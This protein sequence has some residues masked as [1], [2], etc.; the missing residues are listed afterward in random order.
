MKTLADYQELVADRPSKFAPAD[1]WYQKAPEGSAIICAA[2]IHFYHRAIDGFSVCE[3]LR[4]PETDRTGVRP[5]WRC[6]FQT[7]DGDVF[8]L[9]EN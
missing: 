2:C 3:I 9:L 6:Q 7:L 1:V 4:S 8:P 5:D